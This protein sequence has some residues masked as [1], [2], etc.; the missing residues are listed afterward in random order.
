MNFFKRYQTELVLLLGIVLVYGLTALFNDAYVTRF[1]YNVTT[2]ILHPAA[3]LG[4]FA[5]GA[6]V[7]IISGG[8]DLSSGSMIALSAA[9]VCL[10][11]SLFSKWV[12]PDAESLPAWGHAAAFAITLLVSLLVGTIHAWLITAI[13]LPPFVATLAS[14]VGL[15]S[16][17]IIMN[18]AVTS[19]MG[20]QS[21]KVNVKDPTFF[22]IGEH[23]WV[24]VLV[25]LTLAVFLHVVLN[26]TVLGRHLYA[27]GGNEQ[28]AKLSGIRTERLKWFTYCFAAFTAAIAGILYASR[29]QQSDPESQG[30]AGELFAIAAAVIG[31]CSLAGG[32]GRVSGVMLGAVFLHVVIDSVAKLIKSGSD[33]FQGMIVG[34]LVVLA[35][36]FNQLTDSKEGWRKQFFPGA[37]G[38]VAI[39]TIG[40]LVASVSAFSLE[41]SGKD[42]SWRDGGLAGVLTMI[43]L[44]VLRFSSSIAARD[45]AN[46]ESAV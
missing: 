14:L 20:A 15:R 46:P 32:V 11:I 16:L 8:I 18:K 39:F 36:A 10:S 45:K 17:A 44:T 12:F 23:W 40:L 9:I 41:M 31:G 3:I 38:V 25:F 27:L 22:A 21:I 24:A 34:F 37:M 29:I 35:V 30:R 43:V 33:D 4:I 1:Y 13:R 26:H 7:V 6:A 2:L 42:T 19:E 28:A 5:L